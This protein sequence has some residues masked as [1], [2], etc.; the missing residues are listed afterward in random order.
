MVGA[1]TVAEAL[2]GIGICTDDFGHESNSRFLE[3][4][5]TGT[6]EEGH[7]ITLDCT[8]T[9][10][11]KVGVPRADAHSP[12]AHTFTATAVQEQ[13]GSRGPG[14]AEH[15]PDTGCAWLPGPAFRTGR[16]VRRKGLPMVRGVRTQYHL[17]D[18]QV[19][20]ESGSA[21]LP[22]HVTPVERD[23][24]PGPGIDTLDPVHEFSELASV[25][26]RVHAD[27]TAHA[28]G[29]PAE[30]REPRAAAFPGHE[31]PDKSRQG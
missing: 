18:D 8:W 16:F 6:Q 2:L 15:G 22:S 9:G 28:P 17:G 30:N 20:G 26:T 13:P 25:R 7:Q 23:H 19:R 3:N 11:D 4:K 31:I 29:D 27:R 1:R 5:V 21:V 14:I 10:L 24:R 12:M